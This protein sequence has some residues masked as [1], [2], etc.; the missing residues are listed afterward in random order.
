[1]FNKID[2]VHELLHMKNVILY[3]NEKTD[4]ALHGWFS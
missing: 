4:H 1:M 2:C 3:E